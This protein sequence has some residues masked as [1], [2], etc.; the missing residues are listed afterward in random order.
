MAGV[1]AGV[2]GS[3]EINSQP[4]APSKV[5]IALDQPA[6]WSTIWFVLALGYLLSIYFGLIRIRG[7]Q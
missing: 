5:G 3:A 4:K 7:G 2:V 6:T 1:A